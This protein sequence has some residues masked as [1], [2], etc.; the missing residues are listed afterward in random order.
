MLRPGLV[1]LFAGR[2]KANA[3]FAQFAYL[4]HQIAQVEFGS[5]SAEAR[6]VKHGWG[7]VGVP[8]AA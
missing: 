1:D 2:L 8:T 3:R 7:E 6:A 5:R 4:T